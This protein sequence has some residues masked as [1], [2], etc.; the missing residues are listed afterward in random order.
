MLVQK[1]SLRE[2]VY[3]VVE[4]LGR[5]GLRAR[6]FSGGPPGSAGGSRTFLPLAAGIDSPEVPFPPSSFSTTLSSELW[7][8]R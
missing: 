5:G 6:S 1:E 8:L 2:F 3:A 7:T 4:S